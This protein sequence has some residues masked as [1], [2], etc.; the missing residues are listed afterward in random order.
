MS[1][2]VST[3]MLQPVTQLGLIPPGAVMSFAMSAA[4][5][6]WLPCNGAEVSRGTY[7]PLFSA[8]GVTFGPGNGS[9]TFNVPDL[10]GIFVRGSGS[11]TIND[12][13]Y[14]KT[15]AAK[16][17][18]ALQ[19]LTGTMSTE[20]RIGA[21][22]GVFSTATATQGDGGFNGPGTNPTNYNFDASRVAR[23]SFET[24]PVNIAL[25]YCIK[26]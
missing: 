8:I 23:T 25:L 6:G 13:T 1:T 15:F 17:G 12:V 3:P 24:R 20:A 21:A 2:K 14:N 18:D 5:V 22:A 10:R 9:S 4:P 19:N 11:Q 16:E 7:S 26:F